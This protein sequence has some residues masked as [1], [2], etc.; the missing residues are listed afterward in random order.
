[1]VTITADNNCKNKKVTIVAYRVKVIS[2]KRYGRPK[3][4]P[5]IRKVMYISMK[6]VT[7]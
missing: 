5:Q 7:N 1:M 2:F 4:C 6:L 3:L